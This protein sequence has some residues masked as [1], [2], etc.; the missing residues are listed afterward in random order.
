MY[1]STQFPIII[2]GVNNFHRTILY[3]KSIG[4]STVLLEY[5]Y[6]NN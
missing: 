3:F 2:T 4:Y 6:I 1:R 5:R